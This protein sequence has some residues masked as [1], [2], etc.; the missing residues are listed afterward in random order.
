MLNMEDRNAPGKN[1][2]PMRVRVFI[3]VL[4]FP[5]ACA[6]RL[7]WAAM[8]RLSLDSRWEM[9]LFICNMSDLHSH[10]YAPDAS[11]LVKLTTSRWI[12]NLSSDT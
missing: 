10:V 4:S 9:K 3:D 12:F 11:D 8:A 6:S 1:M 2:A 7:C 5:V